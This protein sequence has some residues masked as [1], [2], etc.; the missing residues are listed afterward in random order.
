MKGGVNMSKI[1]EELLGKDG[2]VIAPEK[3]LLKLDELEKR[4]EKLENK[5]EYGGV[6]VDGSPE[7]VKKYW[8]NLTDEYAKNNG[9][10]K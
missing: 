7:Y 4:I 8:K 2:N 9:R 3:L 1:L 6:Y 5:Y 10:D